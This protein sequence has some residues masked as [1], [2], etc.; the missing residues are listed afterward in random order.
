MELTLT[1][2]ESATAA[3]A[4][5]RAARDCA[6]LDGLRVSILEENADGRDLLR[7]LL[8]QYGAIVQTASTVTDA[9]VSLETWRPDVLVS[10]SASP[11]HDSYALI[12]KVR[13]LEAHRGGRIPAAALTPFSRADE[14][15]QT[16]LS[17]VR[18]DVPK[19]VEPEV[20]TAEI[21]KLA[22]RERTTCRTVI[23]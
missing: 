17:E 7:T 22:G 21:A 8:Q 12:G 14:R 18:S 19:P 9:L 11:E 1:A 2:S 3:A 15:L 13:S 20:L 6:P 23:E 16:L 4:S 10:D 5:G